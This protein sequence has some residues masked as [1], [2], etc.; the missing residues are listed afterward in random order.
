MTEYHS[1]YKIIGK[2]V[3]TRRESMKYY[4]EGIDHALAPALQLLAF[5]VGCW[6]L[7]VAIIGFLICWCGGPYPEWMQL[8]LAR[9]IYRF[10]L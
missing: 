3:L 5:V 1:Y 8:Y 4:R 7:P 2:S 6:E 9:R 10:S